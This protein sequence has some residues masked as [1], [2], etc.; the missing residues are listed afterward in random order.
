V[1]GRR[2][3]KHNPWVDF[4]DVPAADQWLQDNLGGYAQWAQS[5]NTLLIVTWDE[6]SGDNNIAT[7]FSGQPVKP[8][9]YPE[10]VDH[11]RMLRTLEYIYG[12]TPTGQAAQRQAITDVWR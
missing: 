12:L 3:R 10:P 2:P 4:A 9:N 6:G 1:T 5:H 7:I 8:G 11:Y